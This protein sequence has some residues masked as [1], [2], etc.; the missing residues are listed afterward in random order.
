MGKACDHV[1]KKVYAIAKQKDAKAIAE[2]EIDRVDY[3]LKVNEFLKIESYKRQSLTKR[4]EE[5]RNSRVMS[6]YVTV[7]QEWERQ[8]SNV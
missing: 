2:N 1:G 5:T 8:K 3:R 4:L 6:N 7:S